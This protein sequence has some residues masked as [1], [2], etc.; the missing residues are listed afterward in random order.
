M[1][2][3]LGAIGSRYPSASSHSLRR[4][5][6]HAQASTGQSYP[7]TRAQMIG[8]SERLPLEIRNYETETRLDQLVCARTC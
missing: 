2:P 4:Q 5:N 8:K 3:P 7:L 6:S 1:Q